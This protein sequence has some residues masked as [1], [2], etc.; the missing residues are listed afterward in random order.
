LFGAK[1]QTICVQT[2]VT[3]NNLVEKLAITLALYQIFTLIGIL[4]IDN[5]G[6][7]RYLY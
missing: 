2:Q 1:E 4:L 5:C 7:A 3:R 6:K